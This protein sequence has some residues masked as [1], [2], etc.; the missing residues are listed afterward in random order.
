MKVLCR[1]QLKQF[2][3]NELC[4][5]GVQQCGLSETYGKTKYYWSKRKLCNNK[6]IPNESNVILQ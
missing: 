4:E 6:M 1:D 5:Y 2:K 3:F